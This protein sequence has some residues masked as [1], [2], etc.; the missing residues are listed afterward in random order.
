MTVQDHFS[1]SLL[2]SLRSGYDGV[3]LEPRRGPGPQPPVA[4]Q[5]T[6]APDASSEQRLL[7]CN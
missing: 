7:V 2:H 3:I 6:C 4:V 5:G 1:P